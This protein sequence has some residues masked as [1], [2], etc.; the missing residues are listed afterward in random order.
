MSIDT[1]QE[2]GEKV[3][4]TLMCSARFLCLKQD[5]QDVQDCYAEGTEK[6]AQSHRR[7]QQWTWLTLCGHRSRAAAQEPPQGT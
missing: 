1:Q 4:R 5:L 6:E 3:R 7:W 2:Q